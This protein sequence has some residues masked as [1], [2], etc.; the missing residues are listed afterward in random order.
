MFTLETC[1]GEIRIQENSKMLYSSGGTVWSS[2]PV[3]CKYFEKHRRKMKIG[4]NTK[5]LELGAGCGLIGIFMAKIGCR[6]VITDQE[7]VL[8]TLEKNINSNLDKSEVDI[9]VREL[10]WGNE[11]QITG[12]IKKETSFD[13][14]YGSDIVFNVNMVDPLLET[15]NK[16]SS[17]RTLIF[18]CYEIRDPDAHKYF[19]ERVPEHHYDIKEIPMSKHHQDC[20]DERVLLYQLNK[21][22]LE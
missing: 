8:P 21:I 20:S 1:E 18:I 10:S 2:S 12:I 11:E 15:I 14:I 5:C 22:D 17:T 16:L 6:V 9:Q 19:L 13:I 3:L 4:K 7:V